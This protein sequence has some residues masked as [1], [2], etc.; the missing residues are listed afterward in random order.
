MVVVAAG[1]YFGFMKKDS[2]DAVNQE[3]Q[4]TQSNT[5]NQEQVQQSTTQTASLR[6]LITR[7]NQKCTYNYNQE[8]NV[9]SGTIY[10]IN[11]K[12]SMEIDATVNG[13]QVDSRAIISDGVYY[14]W[15]DGQPTGLKM[16]LAD[17]AKYQD[18]SVRQGVDVNE[19]MD[20]K[21]ESWNPD[22]AKFNVPGNVQ[23]TDIGSLYSGGTM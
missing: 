14:G 13:V 22:Q 21:C 15:V 12:A 8:G 5:S 18:A 20:Y 6:E 7:G 19:E 2:N 3:Q 10:T 16:T 1:V 23:F 4:N 9:G 11:G 17:A